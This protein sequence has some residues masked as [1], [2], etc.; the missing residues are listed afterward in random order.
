M[1]KLGHSLWASL[2][3]TR[4][5]LLVVATQSKVKG[6]VRL[7]GF[8]PIFIKR[9]L[10]S[11]ISQNRAEIQPQLYR[12]QTSE[13]PEG[14]CYSD[15]GTPNRSNKAKVQNTVRQFV[16]HHAIRESTEVVS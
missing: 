16:L 12:A 2:L 5:V 15:A 9:N 3:G 6:T 7:F 8:R 11:S 13:K 10:T 14:M 4:T 1:F